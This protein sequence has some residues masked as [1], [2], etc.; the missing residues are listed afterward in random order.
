MARCLET[1]VHA[2]RD[3]DPDDSTL[4]KVTIVSDT[5]TWSPS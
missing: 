4:H 1:P 3:D 2:Y 5:V